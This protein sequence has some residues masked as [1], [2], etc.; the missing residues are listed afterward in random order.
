MD[1]DE[2]KVDY[3][4]DDRTISMEDIE[5]ALCD[6]YGWS[7]YDKETGCYSREGGWFSVKEIL[8]TIE[9]CI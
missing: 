3:Q 1:E 4:D 7:E 6:R 8:K 9:R 5:Q 2:R